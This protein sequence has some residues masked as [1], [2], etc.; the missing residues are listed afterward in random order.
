MEDPRWC[1]LPRYSTRIASLPFVYTLTSR[2]NHQALDLP[3]YDDGDTGDTVRPQ[4]ANE[5]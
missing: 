2:D 3:P 1:D 5:N 4:D